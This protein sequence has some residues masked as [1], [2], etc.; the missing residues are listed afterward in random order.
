MWLN[1]LRVT[2]HVLCEGAGRHDRLGHAVDQ[3][4]VQ[5]ADRRQ[6]AGQFHVVAGDEIVRRETDPPG[7]GHDLVLDGVMIAYGD[8]PP[9]AE[10]L[11]DARR[12]EE[13][14]SEL[15]SRPHIV[16]R[17]LLEK[18]HRRTLGHYP[19]NTFLW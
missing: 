18:K 15:Q 5:G 11:E 13:H 12:S 6:D 17:L 7:H 3:L 10:F 1:P 8:A 9:L 19:V 16:C 4:L 14:T 2:R